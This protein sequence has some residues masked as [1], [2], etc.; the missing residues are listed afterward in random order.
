[1]TKIN[2]QFS[3]FSAF[4]TPL[5]ATMAGG[6]LTDEGLEYEWSKAANNDAALQNLADGTVDVAQSAVGVS[7]IQL[8][9]GGR[10]A[11][12][13][14]AQINELDGFFL[15]GRHVDPNFQWAQLEGADVL[16][17]HGLQPMA[18]FKYACL[19]A[20]INFDKLNVIDAGGGADMEKAFRAG[21]GDYV[22]L[23]GPAPQNMEYEGVGYPVAEV[24]KPIGPC[25]F[26]SLAAMPAWL[27]TD[28][29]KAFTRAYTRT[30]VWINEVPADE[31][32]RKVAE[33][34]PETHA[35]VLAEC[36]AAYQGL[37][38]WVPR[39]EITEASLAVAQD[40]FQFAGHI[41]AHYPYDVLC[42]HPP[43]V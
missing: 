21:T 35:S 1:M 32:A 42:A 34:F 24:G 7:L 36:I 9:R 15:A 41:K 13:H 27:A 22:H 20:G 40:V 17:D 39:I 4:Y 10:P 2:I 11:A 19:K 33:F 23:Q 26:S 38:N 18:M 25:A 5:I 29:A 12:R 30:R 43:A 31:V 37:G 28:A 14:F 6:F 16:V 3:R 8:A